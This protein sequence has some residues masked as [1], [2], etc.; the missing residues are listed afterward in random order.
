MSCYSRAWL[1]NIINQ[2]KWLIKNKKYYKPLNKIVN[3]N[4]TQ[5]PE[6]KKQVSIAEYVFDKQIQNTASLNKI[7]SFRV[8][9]AVIQQTIREGIA[10]ITGN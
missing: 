7:V 6:F 1:C 3:I 8:E 10:W 9:E 5:Y 2:M 4:L